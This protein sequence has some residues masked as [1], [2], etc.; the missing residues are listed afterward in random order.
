MFAKLPMQHSPY[1]PDCG[2][3]LVMTTIDLKLRRLPHAQ[4]LALPT[5]QT[6]GAA[7]MDLVAAVPLDQ[8]ITLAAGSRAMVP[9]G[10]ACAVPPGHEMQIRPRSGLA[11]KHGITV[12]NTPG[13]ID[14]DYR[15]EIQV[16]LINLGDQP[17]EIKRGER[18]AQA[19]IAPFVQVGLVEVDALDE[20]DR[21]PGG[22]GSTG[23][24]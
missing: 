3:M 4:N 23:N 2:K 1:V 13:T 9:T 14:S 19:V 5:Y 7:G 11:A 22:F 24:S 20:T 6:K 21:G 8:P 12:L 10:L 15:G 17:F 18:I 16:I